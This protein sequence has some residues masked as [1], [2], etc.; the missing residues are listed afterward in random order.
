MLDA[1]VN[2]FDAHPDGFWWAICGA[3]GPVLWLLVRGLLRSDAPDRFKPDFRWGWVIALLLFVGRW[4]TWLVTRQ[5]NEDESHLLAGLFTLRADPVFWRSLDGLTTGPLDYYILFATGWIPANNPFFALRI[6]AAG[7]L[8]VTLLF[9]HVS[10]SVLYGQRVARVASLGAIAVES[11]SLHAD[12]L[13]HSTELLP[14]ALLSLAFWLA[15]QRLVLGKRH[16]LNLAGGF[17]LGCVP[18]AKLQGGPI[19]CAACAGWLIHELAQSGVSRNQRARNIA[20][21][22]MGTVAPVLLALILVASSGSWTDAKI[23]YFSAN[24][25]YVNQSSESIRVTV[26]R[27]VRN[28]LTA[29]TLIGLWLAGVGVWI[30]ATLGL[31]RS[32]LYPKKM[33][34]AWSILLL[35]VA[36]S[37]VVAPHR[38]FVHYSQFVVVP[39]TLVFGGVLALTADVARPSVRRVLFLSALLVPTIPILWARAGSI[40]PYA[41]LLSSYRQN[42]RTELGRE[43]LHYAEAGEP[44][45]LWG[46]RNSCYSETGLRQATREDCT[47]AQ[48]QP[49]PLQAYLKIR[50]LADLERSFPPL[51]VDATGPGGF[52]FDSLSYRHEQQFPALAEFI[53]R[54]YTLVSEPEGVRLYVRNDRAAPRKSCP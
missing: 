41:G 50:Y 36:G 10:L 2:W 26:A 3:L 19:A 53:A 15:V 9:M 38:P 7:L 32:S 46:W 25:Q 12:L 23:S 45:G 31:E 16:W 37:C 30:V 11:F 20:W 18:F 24:I 27:L 49:S 5:Y 40:P 34:L 28:L 54:N 33:S 42:P 13:H 17:L 6:T 35:F 29:P 52:G 39:S 51:F 1:V 48:L 47:F 8:L 4:P 21:L 44:L 22:L 43:L 14:M